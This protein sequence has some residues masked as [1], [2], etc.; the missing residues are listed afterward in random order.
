MSKKFNSKITLKA[1]FVIGKGDI[2]NL[3]RWRKNGVLLRADILKAW[4]VLLQ[5]EYEVTVLEGVKEIKERRLLTQKKSS[6]SN[7]FYGIFGK[8]K[9]NQ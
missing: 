6:I 2:G 4:I 3:P 1:N 8:S 5:K 9:D 7:V